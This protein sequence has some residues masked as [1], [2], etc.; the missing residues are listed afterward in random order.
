MN[1]KNIE[2]LDRTHKART[3]KARHRARTTVFKNTTISSSA[4]E[5][6]A[7]VFTLRDGLSGTGIREIPPTC[8][9]RG[10]LS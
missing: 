9:L 7:L 8:A 3:H 10:V 2:I 1:K 6:L 5:K 4:D